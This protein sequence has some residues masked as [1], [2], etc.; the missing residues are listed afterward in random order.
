MHQVQPFWLCCNLQSDGDPSPWGEWTWWNGVRPCML[1]DPGQLQ[2][3]VGGCPGDVVDDPV[4][5]QVDRRY[6]EMTQATDMMDSECPLCLKSP[7]CCLVHQGPVDYEARKWRQLENRQRRDQ[8]IYSLV[9]AVEIVAGRYANA[10]GPQGRP[11]TN[12]QNCSGGFMTW[13][14]QVNQSLILIFLPINLQPYLDQKLRP[15]VLILTPP[16]G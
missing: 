13:P 14:V 9:M 4:K 15:S 1:L 11:W 6:Q 16:A 2:K 8:S 7:P 3:A 5:A 12:K 10:L